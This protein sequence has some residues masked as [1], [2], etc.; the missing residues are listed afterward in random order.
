MNTRIE[1]FT[2]GEACVTP[3]RKWGT[4]VV[5]CLVAVVPS[6]DLSTLSLVLP[7]I[8]LDLDI[9]GTGLLW[10]ADVS[11]FVLSGL[12][13]TMGGIGNRIGHKRLLLIGIA[14]YGAVSGLAVVATTPATL[15]ASRALLGV[16]AATLFPTSLSLVRGVF[17]DSK[18]RTVAV[19]AITGVGGIAV[20]LGPLL[21]GTVLDAY[22]WRAVFLLNLP[23]LAVV[24]VVGALL[25]P[26]LRDPVPGRLDLLSV[27]L[28]AAGVFGFVYAL[29]ELAGG[30]VGPR[31]FGAL[32]IGCLG[33]VLFLHRQARVPDPLIDLRLFR[34]PAFACSLT[35][36]LML[37][38]A[39]AAQSMTFS[40]YFQLVLGWSPLQA[41][42]GSLPG[43][44]G[45]LVAGAALAPPLITRLGRAKT[46][47]L[48][49]AVTAISFVCLLP[50]GV[51][52]AYWLMVVPLIGFG[53]GMGVTFTTTSD[54]VLATVPERRSGAAL[55]ISETAS[56]LGIALG[57]ATLGSVL[58][59]VYRLTVDLPDGVPDEAAAGIRDSLGAA[60]QAAAIL[61]TDLSA[62]IVDSARA[63]FVDGMHATL[64]TGAVFAT[65]TAVFA[66]I[67]LREVPKTITSYKT[68]GDA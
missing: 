3:I 49:L 12:L 60:M 25:L 8:A 20:G 54:T 11:S 62:G 63:A 4:L 19:G 56:Q 6:F 58:N 15:I 41:G 23:V 40:Q 42:L 43:A 57:I 39:V 52:S 64:L 29:K 33:V 16:A 1:I 17:S 2:G 18:E 22:P 9:G 61:P 68:D 37:L 38:F 50:A 46:A 14:G 27:P 44:V 66:L 48:G 55:G 47:A 21:G 65:C 30:M 13:I 35:I 28:S 67:T 53:L 26:E 24:F 7:S 5:A 59:G 51:T 31:I 45:A 36:N 32:I 34:I 10:V